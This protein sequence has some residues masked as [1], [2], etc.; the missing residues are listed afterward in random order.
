[1][2]T[3]KYCFNLA[4]TDY[5]VCLS[6]FE[7]QNP[8]ES[9]MNK[10]VEDYQKEIN[11]LQATVNGDG[12]NIKRLS[13]ENEKLRNELQI[14]WRNG[15]ERDSFVKKLVAT[16]GDLDLNARVAEEKLEALQGEIEMTYKYYA[17]FGAKK[18][19]T[20]TQ[21]LNYILRNVPNYKPSE[22]END[23]EEMRHRC[24][25]YI[26]ALEKITKKNRKAETCRLI[27]LKALGQLS[28][29]DYQLELLI[30]ENLAL[31][32]KVEDLESQIISSTLEKAFSTESQAHPLMHCKDCGEYW[33]YHH[34][35]H[36]KGKLL[37]NADK[38][39]KMYP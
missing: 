12:F 21:M 19:L 24:A 32:M 4:I 18:D 34:E 3:C 20:T 14:Y 39:S 11:A 28:D 9:L 22:K 16:L 6:C 10:T 23:L 8:P 29:E 1:M 5:D 38:H 37:D 35:E 33:G 2:N 13:E 30:E 26:K 36:C 7:K 31:K 25:H 27:A 15:G 17:G